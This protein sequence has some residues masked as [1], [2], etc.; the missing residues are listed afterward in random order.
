MLY[1]FDLDNFIKDLNARIKDFED[2]IDKDNA[3][4]YTEG[5]DVGFYDGLCY[6]KR[7][8]EDHLYK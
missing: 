1:D 4:T 3:M 2:V 8:I 7:L 6:A 5:Y